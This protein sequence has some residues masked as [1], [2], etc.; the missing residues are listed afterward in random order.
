MYIFRLSKEKIH[1]GVFVGPQIKKLFEN[2]HFKMLLD[3]NQKIAYDSLLATITNVLYPSST[4]IEEQ[5][6]IVQEL[7][8][9]FYVLDCNYSPKMHYVH[10]HIKQLTDHQYLVSDEHGEKVHQTMKNLEVRYDGKCLS[11]ML[12]DYIWMNCLH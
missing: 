11:S 2:Y 3:E 10:C 9:A 5:E 8:A 6:K 12:S 4:P 1:N 7:I